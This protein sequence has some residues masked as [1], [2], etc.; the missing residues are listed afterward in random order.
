LNASIARSRFKRNTPL[1]VEIKNERLP[2]AARSAPHSGGKPVIPSVSEGSG[3][4]EGHMNVRLLAPPARFR[5]FTLG[6]TGAIAS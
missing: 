3:G 2:E 5:A 4:A 6:L 1:F